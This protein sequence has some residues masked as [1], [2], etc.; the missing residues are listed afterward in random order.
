[1][2]VVLGQQILRWKLQTPSLLGTVPSVPE[3]Q[4]EEAAWGRENSG[5]TVQ[6]QQGMSQ[7][8]FWGWDTP[9]GWCWAGDI[10]AWP[11]ELCVD[12]SLAT[13]CPGKGDVAVTLY[14]FFSPHSNYSHME[15]F[16]YILTAQQWP[17]HYVLAMFNVVKFLEIYHIQSLS[18]F[19]YSA[20]IL[21]TYFSPSLAEM[22]HSLS[23]ITQETV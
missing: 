4:R 20:I 10:G 6:T 13:G 3:G 22:L 9:S 1:M 18:R 12:Q 23:H 17:A 8:L 21:G 14:F 5:A 11:L 2:H 15:N 19:S 16:T 7:P